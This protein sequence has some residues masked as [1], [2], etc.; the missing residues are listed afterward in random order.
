MIYL[1]TADKGAKK[2]LG[3]LLHLS[4]T[5]SSIAQ[6]IYNGVEMANAAAGHP[7]EVII[8]DTG[9]D[10]GT[11]PID[12]GL[13]SDLQENNGSGLLRVARGAKKL[14]DQ[15]IDFQIAPYLRFEGLP[16]EQLTMFFYDPSGNAL[17][18]KSF[19][20]IDQLFVS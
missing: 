1:P 18:F 15:N 6:E 17:E 19:R 13:N 9:I 16:G 7:F 8:E 11:L 4:G 3:L 5:Y 20:H 2:K 10:Y 12:S 14:I